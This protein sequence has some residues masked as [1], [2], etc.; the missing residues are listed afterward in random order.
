MSQFEELFNE[1]EKVLQEKHF[2]NPS[3]NV[4]TDFDPLLKAQENLLKAIVE[5][6]DG[7]SWILACYYPPPIGSNRKRLW[8]QSAVDA[9]WNAIKDKVHKPISAIVNALKHDGMKLRFLAMFNEQVD[10]LGYFV[11]EYDGNGRNLPNRRIHPPVRFSSD[12]SQGYD[13]AFSFYRDVRFLL[14]AVYFAG[15]HL[16]VAIRDITQFSSTISYPESKSSAEKTVAI[17]ERIMRLPML[18]FSDELGKEVP[19]VKL[20]TT[21]DDM[22]LRLCFPDLQE[23]IVSGSGRYN[24]YTAVESDGVT[25][26]YKLPYSTGGPLD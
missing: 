11:E 5:Y 13:T 24:V 12:P 19:T 18:F 8:E 23:R 6:F 7:C 2:R 21:D 14:W 22:V 25:L 10:I 20:N 26:E 3:T 4:L 17:A 16:S 15:H 9:Y 1:L